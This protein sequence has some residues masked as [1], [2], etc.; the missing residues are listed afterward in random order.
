MGEKPVSHIKDNNYFTVNAQLAIAEL[1]ANAH[2]QES[3]IVRHRI[4]S[5]QL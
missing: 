2:I 5:I 4:L 1:R 3:T